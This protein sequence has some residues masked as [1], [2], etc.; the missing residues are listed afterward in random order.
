MI[1]PAYVLRRSA[2][3]FLHVPQVIY[4]LSLNFILSLVRSSD[5]TIRY[6]ILPVAHVRH[7]PPQA[8]VKE[9]HSTQFRVSLHAI[10]I[11]RRTV[12]SR[13]LL[14]LNKTVSERYRSVITLYTTSYAIL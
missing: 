14:G 3:T 7:T 6:K 9:R 11:A 1:T 10:S 12:N 8:V 4:S 5:S 13:Q 2:G